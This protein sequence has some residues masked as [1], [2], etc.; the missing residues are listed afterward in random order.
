LP[1]STSNVIVMTILVCG[2]VAASA[3]DLRTRR[4]PNPLTAMMALA[5]LALAVAGAG[6]VSLAE[7][8]IGGLVGLA[9][10]LPGHLLGATGAGD[11]K[12]MA[13][14]GTLLGPTRTVTAFV[15]MAVAGGVIAVLV[16]LRRRRLGHTLGMVTRLLA[17]PG[18]GTKEIENPNADNRFAYAPA[19]VV[20]ALVAAML[21]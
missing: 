4:V 15:V 10:M 12:L 3:I 13:A 6:E 2:G 14:V 9:M 1:I 11:V 17:R 7:A 5:G 16:A 20:G 18:I 21:P 8:V 19:V